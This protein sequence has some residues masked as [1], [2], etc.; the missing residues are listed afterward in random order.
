MTSR[1][2]AALTAVRAPGRGVVRGLVLGLVVML[3]GAP[4]AAAA[5]TP[6]PTPT[7][8]VVAG[9][10]GLEWSDLDRTR[11]PHLWSL[12]AGGDVASISVRTPAQERTCPLDGWLT[13]SAGSRVTSTAPDAATE[14]EGGELRCRTRPQIVTD[15]PGEPGPRAAAVLGWGQ[16]TASD[17][18]ATG[19]LGTPG[20]LGDALAAAGVC[21][22]AVGPGGAV[23]LARSDGSVD[24][25]LPDLTDTAGASALTSDDLA[26][27]LTACP[28][29]VVDLGDLP[30]GAT[31]R[32]EALRELDT[33]V[34]VLVRSLPG[35]TRL[36]VTGIADTPLGPRGLQIAVQRGDSRG[37]PAWLLSASSRREGVV[38]TNDLAA[39][40]AVSAG[41]DTSG[42]DGSLLE[43][44]HA[45]R[46]DTRATVDNRQ[47]LTTLTEVAP[48]MNWAVLILIGLVVAGC[49]PALTRRTSVRARGLATSA[50]TVVACLPAAASLATL[51]RWWS[52]AAPGPVLAAAVAI[53]ATVL[54]LVAWALD[55]PLGRA[56]GGPAWRRPVALAALT[57]TVLTVDGLT[58][59]TLQQGSP[60]GSSLADG[61][62]FYG[63]GNTV[64]AI[65]AVAG[66]VLATGVAVALRAHGRRR[67]ALVGAAA[68][69]AVTVIVNGLPSFGADVGGIISLVPAFVVLLLV[70]SGRRLTG[71]TWA[72]VTG[73]TVAVAAVIAI[74]AW[75]APGGSHLGLFVQRIVDGDAVALLASKAAG[76][77]ATV[78]HVPGALAAVAAV[79]LFWAVVAPRRRPWRAVGALEALD[80]RYAEHPEL[81]AAVLALVVV[82]VLGSALNDTGVG[83]AVI[84]SILAAA[85]LL[86]GVWTLAGA[87]AGEPSALRALRAPREPARLA[88][89]G[90]GALLVLLLVAG[91]VPPTSD[92]GVAGAQSGASPTAD[93]A[94]VGSP[95]TPL[96]VIGT[97]GLRWPDV[98]P[99]GAAAPALAQLLADGADA[100]G[101]A[102]PVGRAARC[103]EGGW[104][105]L[106]AG[107]LAEV[108]TQRGPDGRWACPAL[109]ATPTADGGARVT[110]WDDLEALQEG[111]SLG[112]RL[113]ELG[114]ALTAPTAAPGSTPVCATAVGPGA[115]VAL[116]DRSGTVARYRSLDAALDPD[117]DA[118]D[119][120]VTLIDAGAVDRTAPDRAT[121]VAAL[122]ATVGALVAQAPPDATVVVVDVAPQPGARPALGVALA[123]PPSGLED[124]PRYLSSSAT[125]TDGV[126]RL[127][128]LPATLLA[129]AGLEVPTALDTTPLLRAGVRPPGADATADALADI[130]MRDQVRRSTYVWF[131]DA[132]MWTGLGLAALV[133]LVGAVPALRRRVP[134]AVRRVVEVVT[135][136]LATLSAAVFLTGLTQWWKFGNPTLALWV[137][138]ALTAAIVAGLA[139][140]VPRAPAWGRTGAIAGI[141]FLVLTLDG[142]LGTP[143]NRTS[144]LG[145]AP[146]FGARFFGFGNPTFSV[147]AVTGL[148]FAAAVGQALLWR[149]NRRAA[150]IWVAVIGAVA[151]I[152]DVWPTFGADLGGGL[153]L[154]PAFVVVGLA[155]AGSRVTFRRFVL[156]AAA[157]VGAVGL[158][159]L[160]DWL[161]PEA[162]RS[163]LGW[164]VDQVI[165]GDAWVIVVRKA[166]AAAQS[167]LGGPTIWVT[168]AVFALAA[169]PLLGTTRVRA[170]WT[171]RWF[172]R[173]EEQWPLLRPAVVGIW[174]AAIAGSVVNDFG[175]RIAMIALVPAVPLLLLAA[176]D[177]AEVDA[178]DD[179]ALDDDAADDDEPARRPT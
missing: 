135:Y 155:A 161:R 91:M 95:G 153:V 56:L 139:T 6:P 168:L 84:L 131:V 85:T 58:G 86:S 128:D 5:P 64:Y 100:G 44:G 53:P 127:L 142:V 157:G 76:A 144:P 109:D 24:R 123:R 78:S 66:V 129:A 33:A 10:S 34:G 179:D 96:V 137:G 158:V 1:A 141:T 169:V 116:A 107:T 16:L 81:R 170:R 118:F 59:T 174:V 90:G 147:Y 171:P 71:R 122:D 30:D 115:G 4:V 60:L 176:L 82:G 17:A 41:L 35:Q 164:F 165:T 97:S 154:V 18:A 61:A 31:E 160:L 77:W 40:I 22:T 15:I 146:T 101:V 54:A 21:S 106:S 134:A 175:A 28:V 93:G 88:S 140:L 69:A 124:P 104:L 167:V 63:F 9:V 11:T 65:Y 177:A 133:W 51:S 39:T 75:L 47:Y 87:G 159:G 14:P 50:L 79:A 108:A 48:P 145:S 12:V 149:G 32:V 119:C 102:L 138:V 132:P 72:G 2:R 3:L 105:A 7:P 136:A 74:G 8:V 126:A 37:A 67:G 25:Y 98:R 151:M 23:A 70:L 114:A 162:E 178:L 89:L 99:D 166:A 143:L 121:A 117:G 73:A 43:R 62:R 110:D 130:T 19:S 20:R 111:S 150:G 152:V 80:R 172:A 27:A 45:R 46:L 29:G 26:D 68:V 83:V 42:F 49:V 156:V 148:L 103:A 38:V 55:R 94:A 173:A 112:A 92:H 120:P 125:R 113:G 36:L 57:W 13:M 52:S 163:H